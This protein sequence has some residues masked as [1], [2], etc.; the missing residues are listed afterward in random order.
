[1]L[2][3]SS[4]ARSKKPWVAVLIL[5]LWTGTLFASQS[6]QIE[7]KLAALEKLPPKFS[8]AVLGDNRSGDAVYRKVISL[9]MERKPDLIVN[10]GDQIAQPGDREQWANFREMSKPVTV[11]YFLTR[12]NH[13]AGPEVAGSEDI[14]RDEVDMPGNE[15]F[16]SFRAG[17]AL[18][19]VLDSFRAGEE[20]RITGEQFRWLEQVLAGPRQKHIFLFVH[21]PLFPEKSRGRHHGKSLDQYP[22]ERD[23]L[24][25]LLRKH[26]VTTVFQGHEHV[27][28]RKTVDG[29][30]YLTAGG[31]GA[32]LYA[33]DEDGGFHHYIYVTVDG[34][35]VKGEVVDLDGQVRDIF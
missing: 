8:F 13:D 21:H 18:F 7:Q 6:R 11:P 23:R 29:M 25:A 1:M 26:Q 31:G 22:G 33:K 20:K 35:V 30:V 27:Y 5:F 2:S 14:Y 10:T 28:L 9:A 4:R 3:R 12:G 34:D 19:V 17:N 15:L 32:P 24:H 16:Y